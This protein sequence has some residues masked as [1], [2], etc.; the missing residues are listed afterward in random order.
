MKSTK[1]T[2]LKTVSQKKTKPSVKSPAKKTTAPKKATS[3]TVPAKIQKAD[4]LRLQ[5][6]AD[7]AAW[8]KVVNEWGKKIDSA[9]NK[10]DRR[11]IDELYGGKVKQLEAKEGKSY[12]AYYNYVH[13]NFTKDQC[14]TA[15]QSSGNFMNKSYINGLAKAVRQNAKNK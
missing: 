14:K 1:K 13:D 5:N 6:K 3:S 4:K 12:A 15:L 7:M 9:K 11:K 10:A 8:T 2:S